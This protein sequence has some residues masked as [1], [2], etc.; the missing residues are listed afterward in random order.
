M[1]KNQINSLKDYM[2]NSLKFM[3]VKKWN[4]YEWKRT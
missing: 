1:K 2:K 4:Q 3:I